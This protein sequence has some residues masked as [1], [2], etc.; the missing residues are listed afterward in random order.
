MRKG[1]KMNLLLFI[2]NHLTNILPPTRL[3][4]FKARLYQFVGFKIHNTVCLVSSVNI[5]G[6]F[7]LSIGH[8]TF[9]GHEVLICGGDS[10]IKIGN[11][12]DI[13][14]RV[15]VVNGTHKI[16]MSGNHS[17]GFGLSKPIIIEDGVWIGANSVILGGITI[18][19]KSIIAAGS[20]VVD[21]IPPNVI[22]AGIPCKPIKKWNNNSEKWEKYK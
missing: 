22:A 19:T 6:I 12:V 10:Y 7:K 14:P 13:A 4:K 20:V 2:V 16:D 15:C 18:G 9:I 11:S 8:D 17:A 5:W 21:N 1:V 3:Y